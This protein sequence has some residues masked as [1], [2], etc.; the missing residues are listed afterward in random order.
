MPDFGS[1]AVFELYSYAATGD[2]TFPS[3]DELWVRFYFRNGTA[4]DE[5]F[6][7]YSLFNYG[8][9]NFEMRWVDFEAAMMNVAVGDIGM[10]CE[11]CSAGLIATDRVFCSF[12]NSS[13]SSDGTLTS[14]TTSNGT[15]SPAV[16]GVIGAVIA[17][18]IAGVIFAFLMVLAGVRFHRVK[19]HKG[20]LGGFKGS[21]KLASDRDLTLPK[22]GAVVGATIETPGSPVPGGHERVGSWELK[23]N[24][25]PN[26]AAG[27]PAMRRPSLEDDDVGDVGDSPFRDPVRPDERV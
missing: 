14:A 23:Q 4:S 9:D 6:Q 17:L 11:Q 3:E 7:A 2:N 1:V 21:Q 16:S 19:S 12:W 27:H 20:D 13:D 15:L 8:P 25:L 22:G 5:P 26:I 18:V 10:W 24:D